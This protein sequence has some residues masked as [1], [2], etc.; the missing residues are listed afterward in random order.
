MPQEDITE[1]YL[2]TNKGLEKLDV[3]KEIGIK[4]TINPNNLGEKSEKEK[5]KK[6]ENG[7]KGFDPQSLMA[8]SVIFL[9]IISFRIFSVEDQKTSWEQTALST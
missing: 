6:N 4:P 7:S 5:E 3:E 9:K 2:L 1:T 8:R